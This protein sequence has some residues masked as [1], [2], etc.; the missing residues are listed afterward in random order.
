MKIEI[1]HSPY[2]ININGKCLKLIP[3]C[4]D[5]KCWQPKCSSTVTLSKVNQVFKSTLVLRFLQ[6]E[7]NV[8]LRLSGMSRVECLKSS[9]V[10]AN[11]AVAIFKVNMYWLGVF[12]ALYGAG[13]SRSFEF[14]ALPHT[15]SENKKSQIAMHDKCCSYHKLKIG[16]LI[17]LFK[18]EDRV[19][20]QTTHRSVTG[21]HE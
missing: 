9:N 18:T 16:L 19:F 4:I 8:Q 6:M 20:P 1:I 3:Y 17:F 10:S 12:W 13:S 5:K 11:I 14:K 7:I 15:T 21:Y 2:W